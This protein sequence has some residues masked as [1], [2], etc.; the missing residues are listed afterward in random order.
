MSHANWVLAAKRVDTIPGPLLSRCR[1]IHLDP[2]SRSQL[3]EVAARELRRRD[4]ASDMLEDVERVLGIFPEG[5]THLKLLRI[6]DTI[7][8]INMRPGWH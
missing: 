8:D 3:L 6:V 1:V 2:I 7:S 4:L 5:H